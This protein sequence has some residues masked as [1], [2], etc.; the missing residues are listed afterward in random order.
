MERYSIA[1]ARDQF[2]KLVRR[3]EEKAPVELTRRG[4]TVA[5]LMSVEEFQRLQARQ[6]GFWEAYTAFR[7]KVDLEEIGVSDDDFAGLRDAS[8]GR[9]VAL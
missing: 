9:D 3:V 8:P 5:V 6:H 4:K 1:K 7:E 2:A